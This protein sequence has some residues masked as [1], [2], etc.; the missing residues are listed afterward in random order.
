[1]AGSLADIELINGCI[2]NDR[3]AQER[4]YKQFYGPMVSLCLRYTRNPEDAIEV[5]HNG[6]LK[7]YKN[8]HTYKAEK[9]SLYTWIRTI[10]V[11]SAIDHIR[12]REKFYSKIALEKADEPSIDPDAVQRMSATELLRLVQ[13]L[14]P[15]TR[16]VFNLYVI[17][18]YNHREIGA[19][20]HISEG[21][22]KWHLSEARRQ[23]QQLLQ[24]LQV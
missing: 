7:V 24:T 1:M 9:A 18:G 2:N 12:S 14:S 17:E 4:L 11:H 3:L 6:F 23:L 19:L 16:S 22:S 8:I 5:L 20:L 10:I 13:R 15:A 21:T